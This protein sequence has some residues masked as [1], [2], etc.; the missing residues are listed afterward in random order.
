MVAQVVH[1]ALIASAWDVLLY[2]IYE[3]KREHQGDLPREIVVHPAVYDD[4]VQDRR[5]KNHIHEL[6]KQRFYG[7]PLTVKR[8]PYPYPI[9]AE[10]HVESI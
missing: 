10:G 6:M 8:C 3:H 1:A 9:N 7:V 2:A 5:S 4:M